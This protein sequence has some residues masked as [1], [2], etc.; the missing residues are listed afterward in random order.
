VLDKGN[1]EI[2]SKSS[3]RWYREPNRNWVRA[4][5]AGIIGVLPV[6]LAVSTS[7]APRWNDGWMRSVFTGVRNGLGMGTKWDD[8]VRL[9]VLPKGA[10]LTG[11]PDRA[12][13]ADGIG[14]LKGMTRTGV[15]AV[16]IDL[17]GFDADAAF[18]PDRVLRE[19]QTMEDRVIV[20]FDP[21]P[22][23]AK[24]KERR[25]Y[26]AGHTRIEHGQLFP[27]FVDVT[28]EA[29]VAAA[30]LLVSRTLTWK[31][32]VLAIDR[33]RVPL[34]DAKRMIFYPPARATVEKHLVAAADAARKL[35]VQ[36]EP[37]SGIPA[38]AVVIVTE[39]DRPGSGYPSEKA[40]AMAT[41]A[42]HVLNGRW[43]KP[44]T[45]EWIF[46]LMLAAVGVAIAYFLQGPRLAVAIAGFTFMTI[47]STTALLSV[48]G[49]EHYLLLLAAAALLPASAV[50]ADRE[51]RRYFTLTRLR[52]NLEGS[53]DSQALAKIAAHPD[54]LDLAPKERMATVL[55]VGLYDFARLLESTTARESFKEAKE[56][57]AIIGD[58]AREHHA[59]IDR[60]TGEHLFCYFGLPFAGEHTVWDHADW[61]VRCARA[62]HKE[63]AKRNASVCDENRPVFPLRIGISSD[64]VHVGDLA[65][66]RRIELGVI[67]RA[68][69]WAAALEN[70]CEPHSVLIS[71]KTRELLDPGLSKELKLHA[72]A[73]PAREYLPKQAFEFDPF[74]DSPQLKKVVDSAY[75]QFV[76][77]KRGFPRVLV[78]TDATFRISTDKGAA[79]VVDFSVGGLALEMDQSFAQGV[80]IRIG[81]E[82]SGANLASHLKP[83]M[84]DSVDCEVRWGKPLGG[85][86][87]MGVQVKGIDQEKQELLK[88]LLETFLDEL[89]RSGSQKA[90]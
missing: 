76:G 37:W 25:I 59:F 65:G 77:R 34:D 23:P 69:T 8:R 36:G 89:P 4:S 35:L 28:A 14:F 71:S 86:F 53:L 24:P 19:A 85:K 15:R 63:V 27:A 3:V 39:E 9:L 75:R 78:P 17:P 33:Q 49:I 55:R 13:K 20:A 10:T 16:I 31:D 47:L 5:V 12:G 18:P 46:V 67:G 45:G 30:P 66:N 29:T 83:L 1:R 42:S 52:E 80:S 7:L 21:V 48:F 54:K 44:V 57:L 51:L 82:A 72:R 79:R 68:V 22:A 87:L 62:M 70:V 88:L 61:A 58:V 73:L 11:T 40:I 50:A 32:G 90:A 6:L 84:L 41:V 26:R 56:L 43:T 64:A 81:F 38:D 74:V 60:L 2:S